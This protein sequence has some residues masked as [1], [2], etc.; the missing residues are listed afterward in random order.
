MTY[1]QKELGMLG[2]CSQLEQ[3]RCSMQRLDDMG[4][5]DGLPR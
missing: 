4:W 1:I 3:S 2:P 5:L